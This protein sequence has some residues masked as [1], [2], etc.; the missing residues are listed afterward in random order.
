M[1]ISDSSDPSPSLIC[2]RYR[3]LD[4]IESI[5][6]EGTVF[7][8]GKLVERYSLGTIPKIFR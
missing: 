5:L 7:V 2:P 8:F 1:L 3:G 6:S 4:F